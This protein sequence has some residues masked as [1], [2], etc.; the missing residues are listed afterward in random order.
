MNYKN[1]YGVV[2]YLKEKEINL[3][4]DIL[5][6]LAQNVSRINQDEYPILKCDV[7][8]IKRYFGEPI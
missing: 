8:I 1:M 3:P 6:F 4:K 7:I 2:C 5:G